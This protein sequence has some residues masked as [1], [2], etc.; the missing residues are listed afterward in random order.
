[1]AKYMSPRKPAQHARG[2][3]KKMMDGAMAPSK[4]LG[5][6]EAH[7]RSM[8][9]RA[10]S[11]LGS[12]ATSHPNIH[13]AVSRGHGPGNTQYA[14]KKGLP[15]AALMPNPKMGAGRGTGGY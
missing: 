3:A 1:M 4:H 9:E 13:G 7:A 5:H 12:T 8:H 11:P 6:Y 15:N 10:D 2:G 14:T